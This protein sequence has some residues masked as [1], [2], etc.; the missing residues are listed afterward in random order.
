M[1]EK[2]S[3][4][5]NDTRDKVRISLWLVAIWYTLIC[6]YNIVGELSLLSRTPFVPLTI[7]DDY[8]TFTP[9]F[10][11]G[12]SL[13]FFLPLVTLFFSLYKNITPRDLITFYFSQIFLLLSCYVFYLLF[14]STASSIIVDLS[15]YPETFATWS[16]GI[17]Y[18]LGVP[19]NAFPSYHVAPI[20]LTLLFI[21]KKAPR[22]FWLLSPI[23]F[24][25]IIAT[26]FIKYH[27]VLDIV[28][29]IG[30]GALAYY[31]FYVPLSNLLN[32]RNY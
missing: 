20:I 17:L 28:G 18:Q 25:P 8:V 2:L 7:L 4:L 31:F 23:M 19:Y 15:S 21:Y 5:H 11:F 16:V 14:P 29:G 32:K 1:L 30:F 6:L 10:V 26:V 9:A 3:K 13:M 24:V 12:Y 22:Y 27:F